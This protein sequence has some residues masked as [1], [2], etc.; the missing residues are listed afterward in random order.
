MDATTHGA[1]VMATYLL[2]TNHLGSCLHPTSV[3]RDKV[4]EATR[5]GS[6]IGTSVPALCEVQVLIEGSKDPE[7]RRRF[8][9]EVLRSVRIWPID[10]PIASHYGIIY[11]EL[12]AI[13]RLL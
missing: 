7:Q 13:G 1:F 11:H 9:R 10:P 12:R 4:R 5:L 8:L 3:L 2:D 6:R